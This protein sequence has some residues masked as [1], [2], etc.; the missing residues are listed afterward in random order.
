MKYGVQIIIANTNY[1]GNWFALAD[2]AIVD[3][4]TKGEFLKNLSMVLSKNRGL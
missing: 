1:N 3:T 4:I 2:A